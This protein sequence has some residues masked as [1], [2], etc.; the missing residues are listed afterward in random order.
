VQPRKEALAFHPLITA[1]LAFRQLQFL[2][3]DIFVLSILIVDFITRFF[4][5]LTSHPYH[6]KYGEPSISCTT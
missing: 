2:Y 5:S 4:T 3:P 6:L 1:F